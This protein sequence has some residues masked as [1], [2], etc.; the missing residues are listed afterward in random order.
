MKIK[1]GFVLREVAEHWFVL[2]VGEASVSFDGMLSLNESGVL[3]WKKMEA[4][5]DREA[6]I[7]ALLEEYDVE[8]ARAIDDVD[9]FIECLMKAGCLE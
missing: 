5:G 7:D 1:N 3:L 9:A 2:P 8:R 4:G 6:M